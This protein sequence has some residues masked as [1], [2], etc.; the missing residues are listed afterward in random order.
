MIDVLLRKIKNFSKLDRFSQLWFI[1]VWG[2]LGIYR[3]IILTLSFQGIAP[4]LGNYQGMDPWVPLLT[5]PLEE[6]ARAIQRVISLAARYTP[7]LSDCFPQALAAITLLKLYGVAYTLF[8]GVTRNQQAAFPPVAA[9]AWVV[10]GK[11][12]VTGGESFASNKILISI[13]SQ[14]HSSLSGNYSV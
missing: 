5:A 14:S 2:L 12:P 11:V 13:P 10:A 3:G 4:R 6:R 8:F 7:W 1:P 9:H